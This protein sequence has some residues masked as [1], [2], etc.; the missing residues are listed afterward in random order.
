ML[1]NITKQFI[2]YAQAYK[3]CQKCISYY[4]LDFV[5]I[6]D[7]NNKLFTIVEFGNGIDIELPGIGTPQVY[8]FSRKCH[9]SSPLAWLVKDAI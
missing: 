8:M 3:C 5:V 2:Y 9:K 1:Q 6:T 4:V 7:L